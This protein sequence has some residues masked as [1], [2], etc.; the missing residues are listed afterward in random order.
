MII[1][2]DQEAIPQEIIPYEVAPEEIFPAS[3]TVRQTLCED[4]PDLP[5]YIKAIT[6][7]HICLV[8]D[9]LPRNNFSGLC[10]A[11]SP[12]MLH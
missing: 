11:E 9:C 7:L 2:H 12:L 6:C 1:L 5:I 4:H 10:G 3:I 8:N